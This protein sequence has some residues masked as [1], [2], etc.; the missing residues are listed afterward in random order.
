MKCDSDEL[1]PLVR[2]LNLSRD[3]EDFLIH[4]VWRIMESAAD[5]AWNADP[6]Q[7]ALSCRNR[8]DRNSSDEAGP[9]I[10]LSTQ[11]Y[12]WQKNKQSKQ[13]LKEQAEAGTNEQTE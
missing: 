8:P 9:V 13:Q 11:E 5:R 6:V 7:L 2:S 10:E 4:T 3:R 12:R 1:R